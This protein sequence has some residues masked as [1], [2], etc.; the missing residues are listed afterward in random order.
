LWIAIPALLTPFWALPALLKAIIA[1]TGNLLLAPLAIAII[2]FF[3]NRPRMGEFKAGLG[4]NAVLA[5]TLAFAL[6][7]GVAG[8][9]RFLR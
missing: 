3:V 6:T 8:L 2:F 9:V 1:M 4:R 5:V 7:L